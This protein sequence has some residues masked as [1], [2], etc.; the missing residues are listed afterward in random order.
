VAFDKSLELGGSIAIEMQAL[1]D[2]PRLGPVGRSVR[3]NQQVLDSIELDATVA[4]LGRLSAAD[5]ILGYG[6]ET[7]HD[8]HL[9]TLAFGPEARATIGS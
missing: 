3:L 1:A 6:C 9:A 8:C 7:R 4:T 2:L 5:T